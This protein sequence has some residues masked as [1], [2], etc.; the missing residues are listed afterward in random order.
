MQELNPPATV[1]GEQVTKRVATVTWEGGKIAPG[2]FDEFGMSAKVP[3]AAGQM[4]AFPAVQTYSSGE[5]VRWI[6]PPDADEPALR[7]T[8]GPKEEEGA[9]ATP[10]S[11]SGTV[12]AAGDDTEAADDDEG[13]TNL[14][15]G[16]A[17]AH[18]GGGARGF[19]STMT[20]IQPA[21]PGIDVSI[22]DSDD[23]VALRNRTGETIVVPGYDGEP[24]LRFTPDA[25]YRNERSP[26]TYLNDERYGD[27]DVP[28]RADAKAAPEWKQVVDNGYY[29][30]HDHRIHWM[31]PLP[32]P[33]VRAAK[34][35][36]HHV[37]DW[38]LPVRVGGE[39]VV[40]VGSLDYAPPP[41][42]SFNP[43]LILPVAALALV[44]AGLWWR[45]GRRL[46]RAR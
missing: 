7:V 30:W 18:G 2:E 34:D 19:T 33:Q 41:K 20:S 26:A 29:E 14:A 28:A 13:K 15:L 11:Q 40:L 25:V 27:V 16:L 22:L 42:S 36:P 5:V 17:A 6:G 1:F 12:A 37:F 45:R 10:T 35:E 23:R 32:P 39:P 8:L 38:K 24:Y 43:L 3:D 4:L 31:S 46:V 9:P 21:M 44:G